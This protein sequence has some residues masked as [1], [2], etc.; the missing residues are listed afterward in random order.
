MGFLVKLLA[1]AVAGVAAWFA[2]QGCC[3]QTI[4]QFDPEE[5][6]GPKSLASKQDKGIKPFKVKFD[7]AMIKDLK[8][9]LKNHRPFVPPLEGVGF[10]YGFNTAQIDSWLSYWADKYNFSERENFLNQFPQYKTNI[11][12]LD[13]HFIRVKPQVPNNVQ[14]VPLLLMHGWPGSVREFYEAIPLLTKQT[15]GYNFVFE[16]IAPSIPGYGFSDPAVR[17]GLGL[18]QVSVIFKNLMNRLGHK[19][20]Y[21]QGG[22]WGA[23]IASVM[24]T[25]FP[26]DVLGHHSNMLVS[27]HTCSMIRTAVGAVIP[28]LIVDDHLADRMYPLSKFFAYLLEE[29]G[30]M[31]LQATKPDT[32]GVSLTDSPAGLMA[33]FLEK[34]STWT[35]SGFKSRPDGG[36]SE[37]FTKDQ[38]IDNLMIYWSTNSITTSMRF[39]AENMSKRMFAFGLDK[40]PTTVPTWALQAKHEIFYQSPTVLR[41]KF[42]N[43]LNATVLEDGGHFLAFE[44]PKVFSEDVFKAVK[45]F[46]EWHQNNPKTELY[47]QEN[48]HITQSVSLQRLSIAVVLINFIY[49]IYSGIKSKLHNMGTLVKVLAVAIAS[50]GV[51]FAWQ[52]CRPPTVPYFD[53]EEWWGPKDLVSKQDKTIRPFKI[54]FDDAM[55]KDLKYRLKNHRPFVSPLEGVAFQYG[56][57][58]GQL[59]SWLTYWADKY[60]FSERENFLNQFPQYKTNIQGLDIHFIRVKPEVPNNVQVVPL[61]LMHGWPGSVR[62]FYEAIPL[63]TKQNPGYNFV[64]EVIAPS[65]PGFG[66]SDSA[67]RP[68]FSVPQTAVIFKN[69]MN[70]LGHDKFYVQGGDAGAVIAS[71]LATLYPEDI[72]GHHSNML[73]SQHN[74]AM[75]KTVVGAFIPSLIVDSH[76]ADRMYPLSTFIE[77]LLEEFGYVHLQATKPDTLGV[78]LS[79]S[80]AGLLAYILEKFSTWT[81]KAFKLRPDGGL[82]EKFTKDQLIDNLMVYW[83]S[84][85]IA[86]S[87]RYYAEYINKKTIEYG[88]DQIPTNVPTWALQAKHEL[89]YQSPTVLR[90]KFPNLIDTTVLDD[91]GHFLAFELPKVF[92]EDVFKAVK[93]FQEWHQNNPKTE[94]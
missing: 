71:T 9:R 38:L 58:T 55:I 20:F 14:V 31:H 3:P 88:L 50:V 85:S 78:P 60:N 75:M 57:N 65:I 76:L 42:H 46:Q 89:F 82:S 45:A 41:M 33:Y 15:P 26:D 7:E 69:L 27:Q 77:Y 17:P 13:I 4:P 87:I 72:L 70:R 21:V 30:Y 43:L 68:G 37:R 66:Y 6:W 83:S 93:A 74:C 18:P 10:E 48:I 19:K 47:K 11:Q 92:S 59:D 61:L 1:V 64:F 62:E 53:P 79:D 94:L 29:F 84:N 32:V 49:I 54:K 25:I 63:L 34:F 24:S 91:G 44:L 8:Y 2:W 80:P 5:W 22:D 12:G 16:V 23:A 40:I 56:F 90:E 73:M 67:V 52:S 51:W 39:Y 36:L 35:N 86:T 81:N 28:S